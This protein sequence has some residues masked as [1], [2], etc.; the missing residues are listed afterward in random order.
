MTAPCG[1]SDEVERARLTATGL[2]SLLRCR[3]SGVA[4]L[5]DGEAVWSLVV[6]N[7]GREFD[8]RQT[9]KLL[10]ELRPLLAEA[11]RR[12]SLLMATAGSKGNDPQIPPSIERLGV[13]S[14][15]LA[16][17]RIQGDCLG[18]VLAGR[19]RSA[20]FSRDEELLL[21]TLAEHSAVGFDNI[22]LHKKLEQYSETLEKVVE[23]RTRKL[24]R[25]T[26]RL[27]GLE[28]QNEL[29]LKAAGEGIY[30]LD[31]EGRTTF[32]NPAAARMLGWDDEELIGQSMHTLLHH[33]RPDGS[34]YAAVEC[35][36]Y[37]ALKDGKVHHVDTEVFWR[38]NGSSFP[39]EYTSTPIFEN[40][41][42]SGAVVVFWDITERKRAEDALRE[43]EERYR[44]LYT[45]TPVMMHSS[46]AHGRLMSVSNHW[47]EKLGYERGEVIGELPTKFLTETSRRHAEQVCL[48]RF[49]K[50]GVLTDEPLQFKKKN[51]QIVDVLLSAIAER[52]ADGH[53]VRSLA[54]SID[55][56][57]RR[58]AEE[59]IT[60]YTKRL[61]TLREIDRAIL[62]ARSPTSIA[63][64]ATQYLRQ[65]IPCQRATV[66]VFDFEAGESEVQAINA[67]GE[68]RLRVGGRLPL[69]AF[70]SLDALRQ[71]KVQ[72]VPDASTLPS[73]AAFDLLRAEG[74]CSWINVP[75]LAQGE[76]V[77]T[78]N[79]GSQNVNAFSSDHVDVVCEVAD[80]L[81]IAI[82]QAQLHDE[83]Q[84]QTA[85]LEERVAERTAELEA[86][87]YSVS[88]DLRAPLRAIDGF[89]RVL[90]E[91][92]GQKLDQECNRLLSIICS[93]AKNMGQ[94]ID[95][96]LAFS[97]LGRQEMRLVDIDMGELAD[98]VFNELRLSTPCREVE[99]RIA[100]LPIAHGDRSMVRQIFANLLS[101]SI[102]FTQPRQSPCIEIG[103]GT[104]DK[105][106]V[107]YV[108]DNGVG[109]DMQYADKMFGV[110]QRLHGAQEF[111]G[112][113]VGLAIV[114]SIVKRH[115]GR[116]WG[117]G[118]LDEGAAIYF[119]LPP[120]ATGK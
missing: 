19:E 98:S 54:V 33:S 109:F 99:I 114:E 46:D 74:L 85:E 63:E 82:Q 78:L 107:Y 71:G 117:E 62:A 41:K 48:P 69:D 119:T 18:M 47:L 116:V 16:P 83:V 108:K 52:D 9:E 76:L 80:G 22:R 58:Q 92:H 34:E 102:K 120:G 53:F 70:G 23:D 67:V 15:A 37:A 3:L 50:D 89:S 26:Q 61:E 10:A 88:H 28:L 27:A 91:D 81:A 103:A 13:Q 39:V 65:L 51:G 101:N 17:L 7:D 43:S 68:A 29:I 25:S 57:Q 77:G 31:G 95:D 14:L 36:I 93:N 87:S 84:R 49:M 104:E 75:L 4:L 30:G 66:T 72:H 118:K 40:D 90:L 5:H 8:V 106:I 60:R 79:V 44:A 12:P 59:A 42:P 73:T 100:T 115:G 86:F 35:P 111:E 64:A 96:L 11:M 55:V 113:G 24:Q 6:Q 97:R 21:S 56:T 112:T 38:K 1:V 105:M 2:S 45:R 110:F 94:L 32:V 20:S